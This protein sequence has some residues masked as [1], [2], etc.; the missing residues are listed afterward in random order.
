MTVYN[1]IRFSYTMRYIIEFKFI[2]HPYHDPLP[3]SRLITTCPPFFFIFNYNLLYTYYFMLKNVKNI[4]IK[5]A[6]DIV[7]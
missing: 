3:Y 7:I 1:Q 4:K 5:F 6:N 2:T